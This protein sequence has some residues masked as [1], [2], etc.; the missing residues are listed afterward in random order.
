MFLWQFAAMQ[1]LFPPTNKR[2]TSRDK[3]LM[4]AFIR[5]LFCPFFF[6]LLFVFVFLLVFLLFFLTGLRLASLG[7]GSIL[8]LGR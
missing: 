2:V 6:L 7:L 1:N 5:I 8:F 4:G 3:R